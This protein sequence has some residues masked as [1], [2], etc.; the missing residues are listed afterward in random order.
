ML[1]VRAL[2]WWSNNLP[3]TCLLNAVTLDTNIQTTE[4]TIQQGNAQQH[5]GWTYKAHAEE[6]KLGLL[7][8]WFHYLQHSK[9][10]LLVFDNGDQRLPKEESSGYFQHNTPFAFWNMHS[11]L[12]NIPHFYIFFVGYRVFVMIPL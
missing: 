12:C 8:V 11:V 7:H 9:G 4:N 10:R 2:L 6:N 3:K 5:C 1:F